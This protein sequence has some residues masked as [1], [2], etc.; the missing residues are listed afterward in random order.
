MK[1]KNMCFHGTQEKV[2]LW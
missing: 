1:Q 2:R